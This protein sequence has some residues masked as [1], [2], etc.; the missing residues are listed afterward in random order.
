MD[1]RA[2]PSVVCTLLGA[3]DVV[4]GPSKVRT[5]P[6]ASDVGSVSP[7]PLQ[8]S[9]EAGGEEAGAA[10]AGEFPK[11]SPSVSF[12]HFSFSRISSC[13]ILT[14]LVLSHSPPLQLDRGL[15]R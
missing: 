11:L 3:L 7:T 8:E 14:L 4:S 5:L 12:F 1:V 2:G 6:G 9:P 15:S 10:A 13:S